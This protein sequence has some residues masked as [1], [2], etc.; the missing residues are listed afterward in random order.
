MDRKKLCVC[1]PTYNRDDAIKKVFDTELAIFEKYGID[2]IV[3]DSS[4]NSS[5]EMLAGDYI[6][7]G[8][9]GL[10]YKR[11]DSRLPSNEKVFQIFRWAA[12]SEYSFVWVIHDHTVCN[13]DAVKFLLQELGRDLD[14]YLLHMQ[15][16]S[17][18][19]EIF[20]DLNDFLR[21]GAWR[22]N[23]FGASVLHT[24]TFLG[25][26]D[27]EK[28]RQKYGGK[29]TL[30]YSH[31]GF[32]FER[33]A[34]M[35]ELRA[36]QL[37][38]ERKG[39]LDFYRTRE[40]AWGRDTLRICLE[41]WGEVISRL[42]EAYTDKLTVMRTQDKW[43]LSKYSLLTYKKEGI[44]DLKTFLKYRKWIR[45]IYPEDYVR[46]FWISILPVRLSFWFYAGNVK[47]WITKMK[48]GGGEVYIFGAGRHAAECAAFLEECGMAFDGFLVTSLEGNP[49]ELRNHRVYE[50][51]DRLKKKKS[52]V[53][54]AVLSSGAGG[55]KSML[56]ALRDRDTEIETITLAV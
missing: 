7:K 56:D 21:K 12:D 33:A 39:F 6:Q 46:D 26:V 47:D 9:A 35:P 37:F 1:I 30:N 27:W 20:H 10:F 31:I 16:D 4:E 8:A 14:F 2:M 50:A 22:L 51:A 28:M 42:P 49:R 29:K 15:A 52:L 36:C 17:Y 38:F 54:I 19:S 18:G 32:Y 55:V 13:E 43:F 41:C 48:R 24:K 3:C 40:I 5:I 25:G 44:Y 23:S 34:Q 53:L 45:K 11:F